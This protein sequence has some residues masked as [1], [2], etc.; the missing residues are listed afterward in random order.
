VDIVGKGVWGWKEAQRQG[1]ILG[2]NS[3][4]K[5]RK[6]NVLLFWEVG[7]VPKRCF[8]LRP[9]LDKG[10][11]VTK[12]KVENTNNKLDYR[13]LNLQLTYSYWP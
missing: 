6:L 7:K 11:G 13:R 8:Y 10:L 9:T 5:K 12:N 2:D 3:N 1:E 4:V